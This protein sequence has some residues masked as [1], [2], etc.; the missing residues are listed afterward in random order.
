MKILKFYSGTCGPC[1]VLGDNLIKA[2]IPHTAIN[3]ED[4]TNVDLL[5]KYSIRG[6]PTLVKTDDEGV[7]LDK[8]VGIMNVEQLKDWCK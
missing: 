1:K 3:A 2:E 7:M 5:D 8:H 4:D 6:I